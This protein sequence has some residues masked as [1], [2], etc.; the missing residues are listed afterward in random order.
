MIP[1]VKIAHLPTPIEALP[2]LSAKLKGP[3]LLAKRDDQTGLA[4]GGNKVRKLEVLLAQAQ[5]VGA[6]T[7]ITTGAAQSNHCRQTAA[8][9]AR[10]GWDCILVLSG[11]SAQNPSGNLLLDHLLGAKIIWTTR[12]KRNEVLQTTF[13][14]TWTE[15]KRP[16]LIPLGASNPLGSMGYFYAFQEFL[17][18]KTHADRIVVASSSGGTQAGLALGARHFGWGGRIL[19]ISIDEPAARLKDTV[20]SLAN[21]ASEYTGQI[22]HFNPDDILVNDEYLGQGYGVMGDTERDAIR[23]FAQCEGL[24]LD[25]VYTG[26]AAG[27]LMDLIQKGFFRP[28]ETVLFW[29]TGGTPALFANTY[30]DQ[31]FQSG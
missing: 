18:Q 13:E 4:F 1:R 24:I 17:E 12:E 14:Q 28:D 15:G 10:M 25:P 29:H 7:L 20:S 2:R 5:A 26:R 19:G 30:Q 3:H 31:G 22:Q 23:L 9:A 27:G 6:R 11:D 16:Y 8:L 21:A